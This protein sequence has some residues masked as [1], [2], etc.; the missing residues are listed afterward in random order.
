LIAHVIERI[1]PQASRVLVNTTGD[2][3][4]FQTFG[5]TV[6][7]DQPRSTPANG[8]L[9][10]LTSAFSALRQAGNETSAVLSVPVDTPFLPSDLVAR[11]AAALAR[12]AAAVAYAASASRDHPIIAL[13]LPAAR[14]LICSVF[15]AEPEISLHRL[16]RQISAV[17]VVFAEGISVDPFF[18][19]NTR[20]DLE[21]AEQS[22]IS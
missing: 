8:P 21:A 1:A 5:L 22:I 12:S 3:S 15:A 13:W 7:T 9:V 10:G 4:R 2:I 19:I 6:V 20:V 11:L 16:M 18:N 14:D 17:R